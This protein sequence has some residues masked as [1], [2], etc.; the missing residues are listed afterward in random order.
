MNSEQ[1]EIMFDY[2]VAE[3]LN[4]STLTIQNMARREAIP[5]RKVGR[6]RRY[7]RKAILKWLDNQQNQKAVETA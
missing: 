5:N 2:E 3:M 4:V 1:K 6:K 7:S